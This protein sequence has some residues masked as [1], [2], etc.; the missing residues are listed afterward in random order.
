MVEVEEMETHRTVC[1]QPKPASN[2]VPWLRWASMT[3]LG[4]VLDE[5]SSEAAPSLIRR[6]VKLPGAVSAELAKRALA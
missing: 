2:I 1:H 4:A 6:W 5:G 3:S